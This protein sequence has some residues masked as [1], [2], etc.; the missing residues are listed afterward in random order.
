MSTL[1][2]ALRSVLP[3]DVFGAVMP[4]RAVDGRMPELVLLARSA[5]D[6]A[7]ALR[8]AAECGAGV[9]PWGG[10]TSMDLGMPPR[11]Y[12]VALDVTA[13]DQLVEYE[14]A[15]LT[16]TVEAGMPL[17]RLQRLLGER[18]Q[19]LPLDPPLPAAATVGGVLAT[20]A[21]G[22]ARAAHGTAR[23]LLIGMSVATVE[24]ELV[25]SGGRVVKNV[26]G[27]DMGKLHIGGLGTLGVIV[28]ASFKV[29]PLPAR[30][31]QLA[32]R[33]DL[34]GLLAVA[35]AAQ[36]RGLA[37]R[38]LLLR[39]EDREWSLHLRL[40]GGMAAVDRS[41]LELE[42]LAGV[43]RLEEEPAEWA[44]LTE[45]LQSP[46]VVKATVLP[47]T[48]RTLCEALA[49][50]GATV[51]AYP[52]SGIVYGCWKGPNVPS[53][54]ELVALRRLAVESGRGALVLQ[55]AP[56]ELK[57]LLDVWGEPREDFQLM[58]RLKQQFDA[59]GTLNP[60]RYLGGL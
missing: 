3:A 60:G 58:Q 45:L 14:P 12:D 49:A 32:C 39:S 26:A 15:D 54:K 52:G 29:A 34:A 28:Q 37:V 43:G 2:T 17:S 11:R 53:N 50:A 18:G 42:A 46:L 41:R 33:D 7:T 16:V 40:G 25:K 8:T 57:Q 1:E 36:Q 27:Y 5:K 48:T 59:A 6:V 21:S 22:P 9:I 38:G 47:A 56:V 13:L 44:G 24:G 10:G 20:N 30:S 51:A 35:G 55:R 31:I 19:W 4:N 23:D